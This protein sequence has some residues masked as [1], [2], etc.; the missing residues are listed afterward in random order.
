[1]S[2]P[3][4]TLGF[5][6]LIDS[7]IADCD[8]GFKFLLTFT[9]YDN[10]MASIKSIKL[11]GTNVLIPNKNKSESRNKQ[12][13]NYSENYSEHVYNSNDLYHEAGLGNAV[14]G[15]ATAL[16]KAV[17]DKGAQRNTGRGDGFHFSESGEENAYDW[18][19]DEATSLGTICKED[20]QFC[21]TNSEVGDMFKIGLWGL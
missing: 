1:M 6:T 14:K 18:M 15:G 19:K 2:C 4:V 16:A 8:V 17:F 9:M 12:I 11:T 3:V 13:E 5:W 21:E 7:T 20:P 10:S